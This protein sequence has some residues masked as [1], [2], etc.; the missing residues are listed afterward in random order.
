LRTLEG[1][2]RAGETTAKSAKTSAT[3]K[4]EERVKVAAELG[5]A[6]SVLGKLLANRPPEPHTATRAVIEEGHSLSILKA[7]LAE[8][9]V[10]AGAFTEDERDP[11]LPINHQRQSSEVAA[12]EERLK[13]LADSMERTRQAAERAHHDYQQATRLI[14][15]GYFARLKADADQL[16]YR[17]EGEL[18]NNENGRFKCEMR[19]GIEQKSSVSYASPDLSGGQKAALSILMAMTAVS[20]D[21]AEGSGFFLVDE[22]FS[23][24]DVYKINELGEFLARTKAQYLI[25]MPTSSDVAQCGDWL[26]ATW[27]STKSPGGFDAA[28]RPV[29]APPIKL[30]FARGARDD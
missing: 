9:V 20:L 24:S 26:S 19:V 29:L 30:G 16:G 3:S 6:E 21:S 14:F 25:S 12:V 18:V 28:G 27:T 17:I 10:N 4:S 13:K 22:P 2:A 15:R 23:A 11:M 1:D 7:Q 8:L 5:Q